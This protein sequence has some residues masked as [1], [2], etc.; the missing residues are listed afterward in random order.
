EQF[1]P[2]LERPG[3]EADAVASVAREAHLFVEPFGIA[4]A[5]AYQA[6]PAG[7]A[8]R[9]GQRAAADA[10]HGCEEHRMLDTE[11]LADLVVGRH[12]GLASS[13]RVA[14]NAQSR[15]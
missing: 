8:D 12:G 4:V 14:R 6:E 9:G 11:Q 1:G 3:D 15:S 7:A 13:C 2:A 10:G 5:A